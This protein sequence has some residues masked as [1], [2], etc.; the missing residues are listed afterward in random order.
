MVMVMILKFYESFLPDADDDD[1]DERTALS[2][3]DIKDKN[4]T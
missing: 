3:I 4:K 1:I 2:S